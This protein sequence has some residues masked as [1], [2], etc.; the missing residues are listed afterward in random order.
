[1]Q[2]QHSSIQEHERVSTHFYCRRRYDTRQ[3][4]LHGLREKGLDL[5]LR[6]SQAPS[7]LAHHGGHRDQA[8][9]QQVQMKSPGRFLWA[10]QSEAAL[11][12]QRWAY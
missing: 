8:A 7:I 9:L 6:R 5:R 11:E 4:S 2:Q 1:L 12:T 10:K 3:E